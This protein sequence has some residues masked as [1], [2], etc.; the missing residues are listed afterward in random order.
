M[1]ITEK[2]L[3]QIIRETL[4]EEQYRINES[5]HR[6]EQLKSSLKAAAISAGV[7]LSSSQL[8]DMVN[9]M[10]NDQPAGIHMTTGSQ[11]GG[12]MNIDHESLP[13]KVAEEIDEFLVNPNLE[14]AA[15]MD[16]Y[17]AKYRDFGGA[18]RHTKD[19]VRIK[20]LTKL[21]H[22]SPD[23]PVLKHYKGAAYQG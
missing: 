21:I 13:E 23:H 19:R 4:L 20:K 3:R 2:R 7:V 18:G 8:V 1:R 6:M 11:F 5:S 9:N 22:D 10:V 15:R 17:T 14:D 16:G 12:G